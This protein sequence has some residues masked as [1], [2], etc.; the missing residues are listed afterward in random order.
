MK[1]LKKRDVNNVVRIHNLQINN[2]AHI[3]IY[4]I[5]YIAYIKIN[6]NYF[7]NNYINH[8][9]YEYKQII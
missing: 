7:N 8:Y 5:V 2:L 1:V 3:I 9:H 6:V 4:P